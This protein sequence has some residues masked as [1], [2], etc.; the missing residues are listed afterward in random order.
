MRDRKKETIDRFLSMSP[1]IRWVLLMLIVAIFTVGLYPSLV[2][3]KQ[4]YTI[5]DVVKS[6]IKASEDFFIED[7]SATD[8]HRRQA[9]DDV[10]T[11]YDLNPKI[12]KG[13]VSGLNDAF[14]QLREIYEQESQ[15]LASESPAMP[16]PA[17][18]SD[19]DPLDPA[20]V[21]DLPQVP[22]AERMRAKKNLF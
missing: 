6:D 18:N 7:A 3:K 15:K 4:P 19:Q 14:D 17:S 1:H 12:L 13:T 16:G 5:G 20:D 11:V 2:L 10:V 8:A 21:P 9:V 22:L